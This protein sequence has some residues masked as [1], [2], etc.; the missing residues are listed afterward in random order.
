MG[1]GEKS[2]ILKEKNVRKDN[3]KRGRGRKKE[4]PIQLKIREKTNKIRQKYR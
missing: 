2:K 4:K 3:E 1:K